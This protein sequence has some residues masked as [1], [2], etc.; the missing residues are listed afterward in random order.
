MPLGLDPGSV[1]PRM[2]CLQPCSLCFSLEYVDA[3]KALP[4]RKAP[5][6]M[7]FSSPQLQQ[8]LSVYVKMTQWA[9]LEVEHDTC[10]MHGSG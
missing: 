7:G 10:L 3:S 2:L 4:F 8:G 6:T 5:A 1:F 9:T